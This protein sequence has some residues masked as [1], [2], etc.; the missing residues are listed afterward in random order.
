MNSFLFSLCKKRLKSKS[1]R[2]WYISLHVSGKIIY[3]GIYLCTAK[4]GSDY[5]TYTFTFFLKVRSAYL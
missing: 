3:V 4:D 5:F 2:R 1:I